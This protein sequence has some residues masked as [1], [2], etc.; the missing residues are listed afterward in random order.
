MSFLSSSEAHSS[1]IILSNSS[2]KCKSAIFQIWS[3]STSCKSQA[4]YRKSSF[5]HNLFAKYFIIFAT[6]LQCCSVSFKY[7]SAVFSALDSSGMFP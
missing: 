4:I 1:F 2:H 3:R 6:C 7:F 5:S